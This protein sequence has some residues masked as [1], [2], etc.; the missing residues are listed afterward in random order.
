M[1]N[2]QDIFSGHAHAFDV[3]IATKVGIHSAIVF[4][5]IV[6]W[7]NFN[8]N[9]KNAEM[10]E[11]KYWM[12]ETQKDIA[13][14]MGYLTEDEVQKAIKKLLEAG[15]LIKGNFNKN[16]FDKTN[17]YTVFDQNIFLNKNNNKKIITKPQNGG[18]ESAI[19]RHPERPAADS[20][21]AVRRNVYNVQ[22]DKHIKKQQ[23]Q[24]KESAAVSSETKNAL[25]IFKARAEKNPELKKAYEEE[26]KAFYEETKQL[27][28][29]L[30]SVEIP[31]ADKVWL[32][33]KYDEPTVLHAIEWSKKK[34]DIRELAAA[35]KWAC[36]N[37]PDIPKTEEE[38]IAEN[39]KYAK[40]I[41]KKCPKN[42]Q[43]EVL[44]KYVEIIDG[45][46]CIEILYD[47]P[48]FKE[49]LNREIKRRMNL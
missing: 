13:N 27:Y 26:K 35:L 38:K 22:E 20:D 3:G 2:P 17:W 4:N 40:E 12:Y 46:I 39:K 34:S 28:P 43:Y 18:I 16:P 49:K 1:N 30:E 9:K 6:Y 33:R 42:V 19:E 29:C 15:L 32:T 10:I 24:N 23:Q 5:H 8:A 45:P 36:E 25:E 11:G 14:S 31:I 7:L 44:N 37:K 21:S 41:E 47:D 48:D